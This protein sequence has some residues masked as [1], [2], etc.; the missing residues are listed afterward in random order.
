MYVDDDEKPGHRGLHVHHPLRWLGAPRS[1]CNPPIRPSTP[2]TAKQCR[3]RI[4]RRAFQQLHAIKSALFFDWTHSAVTLHV[5]GQHRAPYRPIPAPCQRLFRRRHS[6]TVSRERTQRPG[7]K[8]RVN[9]T[10]TRPLPLCR[11]CTQIW[12]AEW[13]CSGSKRLIVKCGL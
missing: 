8:S 9:S 6:P 7:K 5:C 1:P 4:L 2:I 3:K 13:P 12:P 11:Q 10:K